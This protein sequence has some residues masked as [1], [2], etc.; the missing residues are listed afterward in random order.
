MNQSRAISSA[1]AATLLG[2][3]PYTLRLWRHLGKGPSYIKLGNSKQAGV[4]YD[5]AEVLAFRNART[6]ASTSAAT[7]HHPDR[8]ALTSAHNS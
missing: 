4:V 5:E 8:V 3:S 2:L 6:F 7:V 1:E